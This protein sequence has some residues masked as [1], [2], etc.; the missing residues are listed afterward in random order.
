MLRVKSIPVLLVYLQLNFSLP[1]DGQ[2]FFAS[3]GSF[4]FGDRILKF[5]PTLVINKSCLGDENTVKGQF[6]YL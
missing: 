2:A 3:H 4:R 6:V 5:L 1:A